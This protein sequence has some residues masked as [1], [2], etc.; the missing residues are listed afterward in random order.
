[1]GRSTARATGDSQSGGPKIW[2]PITPILPPPRP[3]HPFFRVRSIAPP[4]IS[5]AEILVMP[6]SSAA[7]LESGRKRRIPDLHARTLGWLVIY[8]HPSHLATSPF[9]QCRFLRHDTQLLLA[10]KGGVPGKEQ[11]PSLS[12]NPERPAELGPKTISL[13]ERPLPEVRV[14]RHHSA[15]GG[16]CLTRR[17]VARALSTTNPPRKTIVTH[18]NSGARASN[19]TS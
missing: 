8:R 6:V 14:F 12:T 9:L 4:K 1:M 3:S 11:T 18:K 16:I 5:A 15:P 19:S 13:A 17:A 7:S 10:R 2:I